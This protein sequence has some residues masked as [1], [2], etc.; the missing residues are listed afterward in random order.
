MYM[1]EQCIAAALNVLI[2]SN[3]EMGCSKFLGSLSKLSCDEALKY[4][5]LRFLRNS[6]DFCCGTLLFEILINCVVIFD[7]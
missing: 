1:R 4:R 2:V 3:F 7:A 6:T 5:Y